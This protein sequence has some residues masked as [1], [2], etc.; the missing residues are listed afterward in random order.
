MRRRRNH[1]R[2]AGRLSHRYLYLRNHVTLHL[3]S[4]ATLLGSTDLKTILERAAFRSYTDNYVHQSLI[5]GENLHD[6][7]IT[8]RGVIKG[9]G[10]DRAFSHSGRTRATAN[11]RT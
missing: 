8:G 1:P 10:A 9:Q 3:S 6:I 2:P 5:A 4:G 7:A 11:G